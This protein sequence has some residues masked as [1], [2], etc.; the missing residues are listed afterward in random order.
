[1]EIKGA[2]CKEQAGSSW[3]MKKFKKREKKKNW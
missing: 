3:Q 1:V 2:V